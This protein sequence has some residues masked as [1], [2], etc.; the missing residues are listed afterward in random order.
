M[1]GKLKAKSD[2]ETEDDVKDVLE[3]SQEETST[4]E[5]E[6]VEE[7]AEGEAQAEQ[8][9]KVGDE[10]LS[11]DELSRLIGKAREVE[12]IEKEQNID[13]K[14]LYPDYTK[15]SQLLSDPVKLG[16]Y[17]AEK[18]GTEKVQTPESQL[19]E[20]AVKEAREVY[21]IVTKEDLE[22]FKK[23]F[24]EELEVDYLLQDA[25]AIEKEHGVSKT[26]LL[27]FMKVAKIADPYQAAE[28]I[29]EYRKI[30][31]G[32][33]NEPTKPTFTEKSGSSGT[34]VPKGKKVPS[35]N[36][37]EGIRSLVTDML[38]SPGAEESE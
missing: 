1:P 24:K 15:K 2:S 14:Q 19:R 31:A 33:N 25:E 36:D 5:S 22:I 3:E 34:H 29:V 21:G 20:Q 27:D 4:E 18:F 13:I 12:G 6:A 9:I 38:S 37:T 8:K 35:L 23:S 26:D 10:E 16:G 17:I 30:Q 11:S 32:T 28:K 7:Q